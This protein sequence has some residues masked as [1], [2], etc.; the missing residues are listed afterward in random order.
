MLPGHPAV[1][2]P[3]ETQSAVIDMNMQNQYQELFKTRKWKL[4]LG[5][6]P[7]DTPTTVK[8]KNVGDLLTLRSRASDFTKE[9][10][11]RKASVSLNL[12]KKEAIVTVTKK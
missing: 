10:E 2:S 7:L 3:H 6:L 4:A 8:V 1:T 11:D 5:F 9:S 12:K